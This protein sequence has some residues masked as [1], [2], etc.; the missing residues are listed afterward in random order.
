MKRVVLMF[1]ILISIVACKKEGSDNN[2]EPSS[3]ESNYLTLNEGNKS[4]NV[5]EDEVGH[6]VRNEVSKFSKSSCEIKS[7]IEGKFKLYIYGEKDGGDIEGEYRYYRDVNQQ[8]SRTYF[9]H[10]KTE[11]DNYSSEEGIVWWADS[12]IINIT[13]SE[14]QEGNAFA[15]TLITKGDYKVWTSYRNEVKLITGEFRASGSY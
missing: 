5:N 6:Y 9:Y 15:N 7:E 3:S 1:S 10:D 12:A 4:Y 8:Y 2:V 13:Y 11:E 14:V